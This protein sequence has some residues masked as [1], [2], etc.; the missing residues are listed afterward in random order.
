MLNAPSE[1]QSKDVALMF[2][3]ET[4]RLL[5][6]QHVMNILY[7]NFDIYFY[8]ETALDSSPYEL[9]RKL[10]EQKMGGMCYRTSL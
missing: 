2:S 6:S 8:G 5:V 3:V 4:L 7:Q 1:Y 10:L 9:Q